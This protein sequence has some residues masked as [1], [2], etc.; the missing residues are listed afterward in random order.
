[1]PALYLTLL[2]VML[3]GFGARDQVTV[4]ALV[5]AN[6][7][8]WGI[9][10][11]AAFCAIVSATVAAFIARTMLVE[12]P[13]PARA[14]FAGL[15]L[16]FAGFESLVLSP[17][18]DPKEPT[19]SLFALLMVLLIH[20]LTDAA[21]FLAFG[22]GVGM[23]APVA[24]GIGAAIGGVASMALAW[25]RPELLERQAARIVRRL[26]GAILLLVALYMALRQF[27]II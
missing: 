9:L 22:L 18:S 1:M 15:A 21:R 4:A 16:A 2:V 7:R 6:G 13:A 14:M 24:S 19:H 27:G 10:I 8:A 17:K 26:I 25:G 12:L 11:V 20:Q 5:R 23:A 3:A